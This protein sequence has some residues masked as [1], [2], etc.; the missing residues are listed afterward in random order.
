MTA[1]TETGSQRQGASVTEATRPRQ[2]VACRP[3]TG[4][5]PIARAPSSTLPSTAVF[6]Y[7]LE[8]LR[9]GASCCSPRSG[10]H[11]VVGT[12]ERVHRQEEPDE[13]IIMK[14]YKLTYIHR[15]AVSD[16]ESHP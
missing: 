9:D 15:P 12:I 5:S 6:L 4:S 14:V 11:D 7:L 10:P 2:S 16:F 1:A 13:T 3:V 8:P